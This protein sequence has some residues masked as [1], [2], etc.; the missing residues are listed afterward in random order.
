MICD[1]SRDMIEVP[2][3]IYQKGMQQPGSTSTLNSK[4]IQFGIFVSTGL[5]SF[6]IHLN[7][8]YGFF[9]D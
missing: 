8:G 6:G 2:E 1:K 7:G 5:S 3:L 9:E 4:T